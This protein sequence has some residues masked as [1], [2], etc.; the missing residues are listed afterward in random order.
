MPYQS[1]AQQR[2]FHALLREGKIDAETVKEFDDVSKGLKLPDRVKQSAAFLYGEKLA[3]YVEDLVGLSAAADLAGGGLG[4]L[5]THELAKRNPATEKDRVA[6]A[7]TGFGAGVDGVSALTSGYAAHVLHKN[8]NAFSQMAR[9]AILTRT[10]G[11][12]S[13]AKVRAAQGL[14]HVGQMALTGLMAG[15]ALRSGLRSVGKFRSALDPD[16]HP[17]NPLDPSDVEDSQKLQ[18]SSFLHRHF[19][20]GEKPDYNDPNFRERAQDEPPAAKAL[21]PYGVAGA[22]ALTLGYPA[23][24]L[25][26]PIGNL[27]R[28]AV[29][30][31]AQRRNAG[32]DAANAAYGMM[33]PQLASGAGRAAVNAGKIIF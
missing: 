15:G 24:K 22:A 13:D 11:N 25:R 18:N 19:D 6:R 31:Y 20:A 4:A 30:N 1:R 26:K 12:V 21:N 5:A 32:R 17:V 27:L 8:P 28:T 10:N 16:Y 29:S 14:G 9:N 33:A 3:V 23:Y 2:K 7:I